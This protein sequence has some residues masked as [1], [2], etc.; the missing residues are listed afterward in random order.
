VI[1]DALGMSQDLRNQADWLASEGYLAVADLFWWGGRM[2]CL[3]SLGRDVRSGRGRA[4]A[5]VDAVRRWLTGHEG[6]TGR[7]GVIGF[8]IGGGFALML[9]PGHGFAA[10]SV[11]YGVGLPKNAYTERVLSGA[12]PVVGSYGARDRA[13]RGTAEKLDRILTTLGVDHDVKEYP[14]A[15]HEFLNDHPGAGD[16]NPL[17]F[18]VMGVFAGPAG[19]H[20]SSA[21]DARRR[22][23]SFFAD[24]LQ[25]PPP[26]GPR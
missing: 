20:D 25:P 26:S 3:M 7:V 14:Q 2:R 5:D 13:N 24:H 23:T 18:R 12:C 11:N 19:Y 8:C 17:I 15:G 16:A 10:S 21:G 1:P 9:A 6:C 22:I 4:F